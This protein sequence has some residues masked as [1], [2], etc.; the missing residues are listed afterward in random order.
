MRHAQHA[1]EG[2]SELE[3]GRPILVVVPDAKQVLLGEHRDRDA[4]QELVHAHGATDDGHQQLLPQPGCHSFSE[5][6]CPFSTS[7]ASPSRHT[8]AAHQVE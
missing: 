2:I 5:P 1:K 6:D 3:R 8:T 7:P 4:R